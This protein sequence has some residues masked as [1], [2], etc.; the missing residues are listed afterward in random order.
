MS[1]R[2]LLLVRG[3]DEFGCRDLG[4]RVPGGMVFVRLWRFPE[5]RGPCARCRQ[6]EHVEAWEPPYC[7][8]CAH[9]VADYAEGCL[10]PSFLEDDWEID[11]WPNPECVVHAHLV[12]A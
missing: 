6:W 4:V 8:T 5:F 2:W 3:S 7:S 1:N 10:C 11:E 12:R 9:E